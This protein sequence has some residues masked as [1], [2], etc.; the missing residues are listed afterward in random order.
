MTP[1]LAP[2]KLDQ[3]RQ[4]LLT[5]Q[6]RLSDI[7]HE[8][9]EAQKALQALEPLPEGISGEMFAQRQAETHNLKAKIARLQEKLAQAQREVEGANTR[10]FQVTAR[11]NR[12]P[13]LLADIRRHR[14]SLERNELPRA[15]QQLHQAEGYVRDVEAMMAK[16][17]ADLVTFEAEYVALTGKAAV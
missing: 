3:A 11:A 8:G 16:D 14:S 2:S 6:V 1:V 7:R 15:R 12:L 4:A 10:L 9:R 13:S 17:A 5:A